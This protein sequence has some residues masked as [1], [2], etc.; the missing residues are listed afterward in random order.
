VGEI[1]SAHKTRGGN[2]GGDIFGDLELSAH[3]IG[4]CDDAYE[5]ALALARTSSRQ[6][7][8]LKDQQ[9][10][11][12]Q[13][14]RMKML[15]EALRSYVMRTAWERDANI[16]SENAGLVMNF[17]TEVVQEVTEIALGFYD[18][19]G[20][21]T[22]RAADKLVRDASIWEHLAGDAVQRMRIARRILAAG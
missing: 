7:K 2:I 9:L 18:R 17:S 5:K 10:V 19:A 20:V 14:G 22:N 6:G 13:I 15:A 4:I 21:Q 12:I 16:H 1:N 8:P 3:A 11:Q